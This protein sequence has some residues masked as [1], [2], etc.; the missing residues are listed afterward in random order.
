MAIC[1]KSAII[2][3]ISLANSVLSIGED[4]GLIP[5]LIIELSNTFGEGKNLL[6]CYSYHQGMLPKFH[7]FLH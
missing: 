4:S 7:S 3:A 5:T 2:E 6:S 1:V